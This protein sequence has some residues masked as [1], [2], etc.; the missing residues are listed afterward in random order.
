M[1]IFSVLIPLALLAVV[2][3]LV[4]GLI[5]MLKGGEFNDKYGNRL[6]RWRVILQAAAVVLIVLHLVYRI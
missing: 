2:A 6:M 3:V 1:S 5:S 4:I